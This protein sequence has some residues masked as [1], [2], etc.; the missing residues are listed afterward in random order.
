MAGDSQF[1][2]MTLTLRLGARQVFRLGLLLLTLC[3]VGMIV[4]GLM[5]L[6]AVNTAVLVTTHLALLLLL[7]V[8]SWRVDP[9]QKTAVARYYL[10][11]WVLFFS[12]YIVFPLAGLTHALY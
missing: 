8:V 6:P 1:H 10:F 3:Y 7:W 2:I 9:L 4:A 12:E 5:G 11:V